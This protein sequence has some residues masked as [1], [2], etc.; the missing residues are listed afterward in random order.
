MNISPEEA[1]ESLAVVQQTGAKLRKAY[2]YNGYYVILWG[3]IWLFGFLASQYLP[4]VPGYWIWGIL[5]IV[6]WVAS[7]FLGIY[8][9]VHIRSKAGPRVGMFWGILIVFSTLWFI[10]LHPSSAQQG[11]LFLVTLIL[12]GGIVSGVIS[13]DFSSVIGCIAIAI[14]SVVGYYLV[15]AY[16]YLWEAIFGGLSMLIIG[17]VLRLGWR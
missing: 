13:R 12:F 11:V 9:G 7:A 5:I 15:P 8:Q 2:G 4:P 17:L 16:F 10:I 6:G 1:Q 14:L 3:L